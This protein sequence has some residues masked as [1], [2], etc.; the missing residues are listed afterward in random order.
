MKHRACNQ[1]ANFY[2]TPLENQID[3]FFLIYMYG[4]HANLYCLITYELF[5]YEGNEPRI[6]EKR[7]QEVGILSAPR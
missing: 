7:A 1:R 6:D 2:Q 3:R 5:S 4:I